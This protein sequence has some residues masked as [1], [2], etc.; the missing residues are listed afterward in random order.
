MT[1][2][3]KA[4]LEDGHLVFSNRSGE[5]IVRRKIWERAGSH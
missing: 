5:G 4:S 3:Q 2:T 1:Y